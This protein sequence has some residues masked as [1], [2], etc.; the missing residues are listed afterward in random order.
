LEAVGSYDGFAYYDYCY[1]VS[2][3]IPIVFSLKA[4]KYAE[5][6][7]AFPDLIQK[8]LDEYL[9]SPPGND[10]EHRKSW[11]VAIYA[12]MCLLG[13]ETSAWETIKGTCPNM[14]EWLSNNKSNIKS[15]LSA[16]GGRVRY[17]ERSAEEG[18]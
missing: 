3:W 8:D 5:N 1:A 14:L 12:H 11:V 15:I 2:P 13:K 7:M 6:T 4:G 9:A 16:M 18:Y 17:T 10:E